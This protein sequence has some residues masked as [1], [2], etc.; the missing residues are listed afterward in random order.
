MTPVS[1]KI[2]RIWDFNSGRTGRAVQCSSVVFQEGANA[3][4]EE[5]TEVIEFPDNADELH[6]EI[7]EMDE[8]TESRGINDSPSQQNSKSK[9][10]LSLSIVTSESA[11]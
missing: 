9:D 5:Q 8:K 6:D 2:W 7:Y 3:H 11:Q 4:T 10:S 1:Q